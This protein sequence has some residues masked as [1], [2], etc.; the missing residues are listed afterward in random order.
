MRSDRDKRTDSER[1]IDEF[2][3]SFETPV[4]ELSA[5]INSYL[6]DNDFAASDTITTDR[7]KF[8]FETPENAASFEPKPADTVSV[9]KNKPEKESAG[10]SS[11]DDFLADYTPAAVSGSASFDDDP[12]LLFEDTAS[13]HAGET[14]LNIED[15]SAGG[16]SD[17]S[18]ENTLVSRITDTLYMEPIS[19]QTVPEETVSVSAVQVP[20]EV[21]SSAEITEN[22]ETA[23]N[24]ET[25]ET[26]EASAVVTASAAAAVSE[27]AAEK[28]SGKKGRNK[29]SKAEKTADKSAAAPYK[30]GLGAA[31]FL[32]P[33]PD[34]DPSQGKTYKK[35]NKTI[36]NKPM[37]V[38]FGKIIR[39]FV[40]VGLLCVLAGVI[41][42]MSIVS[43]APKINPK[44]IYSVIDTSSIIYD[45][46]GK[47][48]DTVF[49]T[50]NRK[51]VPYS[52][53]PEDLINAFVAIEDKTF[54]KHHGFNWTRMIGAV[55]SSVT[56][57][58]RISGTS[59][60][61]QQL[62][63]NVYLADIK[64]QRSIKRKVIEMYYAA[65]IEHALSK[66]EIIEAYL[67]TIYLGHGCYGVNAA[68]KTYFS[69]S[70]GDLS[71]IQCA[72]LAALPQSPDTYALLRFADNASDI[73]EDAKV[74]VKEPDTIVTNDI[75]K[76]RRDLTLSLMLNQGYITQEQYDDNVGLSLNT[77]IE[78]TISSTNGTYSYFRE[79]LVDT[80]IA[81][82]MEKYGM[83]YATAEHKVYTN[84]LQIYSTMDRT[85]QKTIVKEFKKSDNFPSISA[86]YK[87]DENGNM[88]NNDNKIA[89]YNY[90]HFFDDDGNFTLSG[91]KNVRINDDGSVTIMKDRH[92]NIYQ[93]EVD[94]GTDY[95]LEFKDYYMISKDNVYSIQGG[96]I[97]VPTD[98]KSMDG[99]GNLVIS[100]DY[101]TDPL[102]EGS[103]KIDGDKLIITDDAYSLASRSIQ[104]QAAMVIVGVGTGEVK[105][106]V[107]GR[108]F[109]GQ[110]LLNRA[111]NPRQPGSSIKPLAVYGA[112]LQKSYEL[113]EGKQKWEI[114]DYGIDK[115]GKRGWG[116]YITVHSSVED[117]RT[118][119]EGKDWPN[120][121]TKSFSGKN[122]F[123]TAIQKSIN[124]CAVKILL[125][126]GAEYSMDQLHRFGITTAVDDASNPTNDINPAALALGAMCEGVKPLEMALAYASF[127]GG[128]KLNTPVCY[129]KVLDRNGEVLLESNST[130]TEALNE[131]VAWIM[132]DVLKS[133][134]RANGYD[135]SE[136]V[137]G[138][139][140][141]T[142]NDQYDIWF[143]G[144]TP[145][146]AASLWIG[147]DQNVEM[148][149]MSTVAAHLWAKIMKQIPK[150]TEGEYAAQPSNVINVGGEYFTKGTETGL[151]SW[152][153]AEQ[154]KKERAAAKKKW[155][156]EREK[157]KKWVDEVGH[158]K[159]IHHDAVT[160]EEKV[161]VTDAWDEEVTVGTGEYDEEGNEIMKT[162]IKH[163]DAVYETRTVED[164]PA[165]DETTKEWVVDKKGYWEYEKGWRDGDFKY[166]GD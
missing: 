1:E 109:K 90:D 117:E 52:D 59:T 50:E 110:K 91:K 60:I 106:M 94:G 146:Y 57:G 74:I 103:M 166:K 31:L 77:F 23:E 122:T 115:Q 96:Y 81:D 63:R 34:Y 6:D 73:S 149:S 56:G 125:Q 8:R 147:T 85:A 163:H 137:T 35:G 65:K 15:D 100:A 18:F 16:L 36:R 76:D 45:D 158:Y 151:T 89:L 30:K 93:T 128:G 134:V 67:N 40:V 78:P 92:L 84:G 104:P 126:V 162:E 152:S 95:S 21:S 46:Q 61:T 7:I 156:K 53:M 80:V 33:N 5:D 161:L 10:S 114:V 150:A 41:A 68:A 164:S 124:T 58:G 66:E 118:H 160:H 136:V 70:V 140:T 48:V 141:G 120:N 43:T 2:L 72:S 13:E 101:F 112:A 38:S 107:G 51:I 71:L 116:D 98:Y 157:H 26:A 24:T 130:Q 108:T 127:P 28:A 139:K 25:S 19:D 155:L 111:I 83:D 14:V 49:Y 55:L 123:K 153:M 102:Y 97:N 82:L 27:E 37:K 11:E 29:K 86:I 3:S 143:D 42:F 119:I 132:T 105:A 99:D 39:D 133:V 88:L 87:T 113:A 9:I 20:E 145:T 121:V 129:T 165:Y 138:G 4:E 148:S 154:K 54:W 79:Y 75:S 17:E 47:Q 32:K 131:G 69:K 64:S 142:T 22:A 159:V 62:S 44:E 12:A 144:F 135:I